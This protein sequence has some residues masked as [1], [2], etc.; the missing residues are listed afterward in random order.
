MTM[1]YKEK[2]MILSSY[3]YHTRKIR[4]L[5]EELERWQSIGTNITQ[6][7]TP[8][9][10]H[11]ND[12]TSKVERCAIKCAEIEEQILNE[13]MVAEDSRRYILDAIE[14]V[15]D[16]RRKE[17]LEMRFISGIS[18]HQIAIRLDKSEDNI[19]KLLRTSI[20]RIEL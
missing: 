12:N 4:S 20:K 19:Y 7:I 1:T 2:Q 3:C 17:V 13:L 10:C 14:S 15:Q 18:V 16:M 6:K 11:T 5:Q 8:I 9:I